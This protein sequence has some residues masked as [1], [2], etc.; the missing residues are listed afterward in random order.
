M[1]IQRM[2]NV[3]ATVVPEIKESTV[4][5]SKSFRQ[6]LSN[7]PGKQEIKE[8]QKNSRIGHCTRTTEN[9][10]VKIRNIFHGRNNVTCS[11]NCKYRTD[12]TL[13]TL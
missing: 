12:A 10:N 7:I 1:E 8:L 11:T 5:I 2:W 3:K 4:T 6:Y 13:Y 9:A